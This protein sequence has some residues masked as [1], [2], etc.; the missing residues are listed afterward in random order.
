[1]ACIKPDSM[2]LWHC[3]VPN[4]ETQTNKTIYNGQ[5]QKSDRINLDRSPW[6]ERKNVFLSENYSMFAPISLRLA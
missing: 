5:V 4:K 2:S 3:V 1:M 6:I